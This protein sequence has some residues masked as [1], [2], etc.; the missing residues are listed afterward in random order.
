MKRLLIVSFIGLAVGFIAT[1]FSL[2]AYAGPTNPENLG[3]D[4]HH[5]YRPPWRERD[6]WQRS[7]GC[8]VDDHSS[9]CG[10][11]LGINQWAID[12]NKA[13]DCG[14]P[15]RADRL[16]AALV[17]PWY[18]GGGYGNLLGIAHLNSLG[19]PMDLDS[20]WYAHMEDFPGDQ[21]W[22]TVFVQGDFVGLADSSGTVIPPGSCHLHFQVNDQGTDKSPVQS[23]DYNTLD[24]WFGAWPYY[25]YDIQH[26]STDYNGWHASNNTGAGYG[27]PYT[28]TCPTPV[29]GG[30]CL[31]REPL[32]TPNRPLSWAIRTWVRN[33]AAYTV[34]VGST[35]ASI[36]GPCGANR[37]WVKGCYFY[38]G[39]YYYTQNFVLN[40][41]L[42][43]PLSITE[44]P[45][46]NAY[47]VTK[48]MWK[49]YGRKCGSDYT[50]LRIGRPVNEEYVVGSYIDQQDF[51][52]GYMQAYRN[53]AQSISI[54]VK[55]NSGTTLCTFNGLYDWLD[56]DHEPCY[57]VNS[58]GWVDSGDQGAMGK[59]CWTSETDP[60][61]A[62]FPG[63]D[64]DDRYDL[65]RDGYVDSGD[66]GLVNRQVANCS[67]WGCVCK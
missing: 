58:D 4:I 35:R 46:G 11:H 41:G 54:Q 8:G 14:A 39:D 34:D 7:D 15:L 50:Y 25:G 57:D 66:L 29:P 19:P 28:G 33:L 64:Y 3:N 40:Y 31:D 1:S 2:V 63:Y 18:Q 26:L 45:N 65:N 36:Q 62:Q 42:Q 60:I 6:Q 67:A 53:N 61:N 56:L 44:A 16:G 49:A 17:I 37:R 21:P 10:G 5:A 30:L 27:R 59:R 13:G 9:G 32:D 48:A 51:E 43:Y 38:W 55:N 52:R 22:D 47:R 12:L 24:A 23:D 20:S